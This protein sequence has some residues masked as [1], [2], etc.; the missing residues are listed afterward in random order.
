MPNYNPDDIIRLAEAN[1][2]YGFRRFLKE[3]YGSSSRRSSQVLRLFEIHKIEAGVDL[4]DVLQDTS[5]SKMV[6]RKEWK[7]I[8]NNAPTPK[9]AGL[10]TARRSKL[11]RK[12]G[13]GTNSRNIPLPPQNFYWL[14]V[15]EVDDEEYEYG[16]G[17]TNHIELMDYNLLMRLHDEEMMTVSQISQL[18]GVRETRIESFLSKLEDYDEKDIVYEWLAVMK[19]LWRIQCRRGS[20]HK[21]D[22]LMMDF[23]GIFRDYVMDPVNTEPPTIQDIDWVYQ[24]LLEEENQEEEFAPEVDLDLYRQRIIGDAAL[25]KKITKMVSTYPV[26]VQIEMENE[27]L[28][29]IVGKMEENTAFEMKVR[30]RAVDENRELDILDLHRIQRLEQYRDEYVQWELEIRRSLKEWS[31]LVDYEYRRISQLDLNEMRRWD[32]IGEVRRANTAFMGAHSI[33]YMP[34]NEKLISLL[35]QHFDDLY[36]IKLDLDG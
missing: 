23:R 25:E 5:L 17:S 29:K 9:G 26:S 27:K 28:D 4:F 30:E 24:Q 14:D 12:V 33:E 36:Q 13:I 11:E 1:P 21:K 2:G 3:L 16:Q 10:S 35:N 7:S 34:P 6:T 15:T 18:M 19:R 22:E 31:K 8:T 32:M 20:T